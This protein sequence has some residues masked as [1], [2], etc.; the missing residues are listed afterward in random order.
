[1]I[2]PVYL[3]ASNLTG[4]ENIFFP[5]FFFLDFYQMVSYFSMNIKFELMTFHQWIMFVRARGIIW[6][7]EDLMAQNK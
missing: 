7:K 6:W 2:L 3:L 1:M 4:L 5:F